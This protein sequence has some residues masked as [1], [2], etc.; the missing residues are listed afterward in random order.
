[1][2]NLLKYEY[3]NTEY[4]IDCYM[5]KAKLN[6]VYNDH[7]LFSTIDFYDEIYDVVSIFFTTNANDHDLLPVNRVKMAGNTVLTIIMKNK[8]TSDLIYW[9][10]SLNA[11]TRQVLNFAVN[12]D[13]DIV[14]N[15]NEF[16]YLN[17]ATETFSL[18]GIYDDEKNYSPLDSITMADDMSES[19]TDSEH[20]PF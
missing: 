10:T 13:D 11:V 7:Y 14:K 3:E 4:I 2:R 6:N 5:V 18:S 20:N 1:M 19:Y 17:E 9:Q 15:A 12:Q 8:Q 16:Y